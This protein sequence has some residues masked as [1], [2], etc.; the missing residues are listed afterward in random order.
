MSPALTN[1]RGGFD[2]LLVGVVCFPTVNG[3][4]DFFFGKAESAA[5]EREEAANAVERID[6]GE[7][8]AVATLSMAVT[9]KGEKENQ[10]EARRNEL[11]CS[12]FEFDFPSLSHRALL[13]AF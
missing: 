2:G 5:V 9:A 11:V 12:K 3:G 1:V 13:S 4:G 8:E 6:L 10:R 7:R